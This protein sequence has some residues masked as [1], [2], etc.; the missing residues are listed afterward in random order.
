MHPLLVASQRMSRS[1]SAA[2]LHGEPLRDAMRCFDARKTLT[3]R[4]SN[5]QAAG[6]CDDDGPCEVYVGRLAALTTLYSLVEGTL[7]YPYDL[8]KTRQQIAAPGSPASQLTT[9]AHMVRLHE[10]RGLRALYRGFGWNVLGGVPSEIA[11]YV[12]YTKAKNAMLSTQMGKSNP[13]AVY[14]IAGAMADVLSVLLWVPADVIS[15]RLMV[16]GAQDP[17]SRCSCALPPSAAR[18][19]LLPVSGAAAAAAEASASPAMVGSSSVVSRAAADVAVADASSGVAVTAAESTGGQVVRDLVRAEGLNG[20]W[21]GASITMVSYAP[22]SAVWWLTHEQAKAGF[23]RRFRTADDHAGVLG[24]SGAMAG[25]TST[26]ATN[27]LDVVKTRVQCSE[28]P[29]TVGHVLREILS[30]AGWRGLYSGV[31]PRLLAAIPR[32]I[33]TVLAYEKAIALCRKES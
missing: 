26:I 1:T 4:P 22:H 6:S 24:L 14:L 27:P 13:S 8:V 3:R 16:G 23:S 7:T 32:S 11:Y 28:M 25:V 29:Q 20:L 30:E 10:E 19:P 18:A 17:A 5:S 15:Q 33:C 21:R 2:M 12:G 9:F 31:A